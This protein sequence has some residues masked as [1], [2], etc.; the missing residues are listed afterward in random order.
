MAMVVSIED[1]IL[2][3]RPITVPLYVPV[4]TYHVG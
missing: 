2:H 4:Q 3:P 1:T